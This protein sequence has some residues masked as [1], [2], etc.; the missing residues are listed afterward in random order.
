ML[1]ERPEWVS[2]EFTDLEGLTHRVSCNNMVGRVCLH[3]IDH[4][5][6]VLMSDKAKAKTKFSQIEGEENLKKFVGE[7]MKYLY[8]LDL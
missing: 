4:L 2:I 8:L 1:V 7:N 6:G 3:E 5:E